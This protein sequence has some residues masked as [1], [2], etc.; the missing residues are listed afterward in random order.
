[1]ISNNCFLSFIP[2]HIR[3]LKKHFLSQ[4]S[5]CC[6][7][8]GDGPR[9]SSL[10]TLSLLVSSLI[11]IGLNTA[12]SSPGHSAGLQTHVYNCQLYGSTYLPNRPLTL[13]KLSPDIPPQQSVP[14]CPSHLSKQSL[15]SSSCSGKIWSHTWSRLLSL[16]PCPVHK[17]ILLAPSSK[18]IQNPTICIAA[19]L[20]QATI[21]S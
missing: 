1:M 9:T 13:S 17:Q 6:S 14:L 2:E 11:H 15:P 4:T 7:V 16:I 21:T 3:N 12:I 19:T 8:P 10:F 20:V 18:Y 5:E